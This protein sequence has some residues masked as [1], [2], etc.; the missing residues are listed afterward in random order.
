MIN[1]NQSW[2]KKNKRIRL[3]GT[4]FELGWMKRIKGYDKLEPILN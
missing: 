3:T 4:N 2:T 1:S